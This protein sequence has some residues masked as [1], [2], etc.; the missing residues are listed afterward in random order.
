VPVLGPD[1]APLLAEALPY[2]EKMRKRA[3]GS[4]S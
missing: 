4:F 3:V 1:D 2:Y